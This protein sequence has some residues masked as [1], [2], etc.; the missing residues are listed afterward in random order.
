MGRIRAS[1]SGTGCSA[2]RGSCPG[3]AGHG[4]V[5]GLVSP[6]PPARMPIY[7]FVP[8][9]DFDVLQMF[10]FRAGQWKRNG[11]VYIGSAVNHHDGFLRRASSQGHKHIAFGQYDIRGAPWPS[12]R[13]ACSSTA[14]SHPAS[15]QQLITL[16]PPPPPA[17]LPR[18]ELFFELKS[19]K[20]RPANSLKPKM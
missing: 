15:T 16:L 2:A 5:L 14:L 10:S 3:S 1:S 12:T 9:A 4:D 19:S 8:L 6:C 7:A 11:F 13:P 17:F 20:G 18:V